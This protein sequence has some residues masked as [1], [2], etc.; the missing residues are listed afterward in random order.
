M[1][2]E[3]VVDFHA[4]LGRDA[5]GDH[6]QTADELI[7]SMDV[8][9]IKLAVVAPLLDFPGPD[10]QV[11]QILQE[12]VQRFPDRFIPFARLDPRY[13]EQALRGLAFAVDGGFAQKH[14][15]VQEGLQSS[16]DIGDG[17]I[18]ETQY[19]QQYAEGLQGIG[20]LSSADSFRIDPESAF[21]PQTIV[22]FRF[23][24][25]I[26]GI[27]DG[28]GTM[29]LVLPKVLAITIPVGTSLW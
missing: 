18:A 27:A 10:P 8:C 5:Y 11:H 13:G 6:S 19:I 23:H 24:G 28:L 7:A 21:A 29:I 16:Q 9:Q 20:L 14:W 26:R 2:C 15:L 3:L 4:Y 25:L 17:S 12:A 22:A 1:P